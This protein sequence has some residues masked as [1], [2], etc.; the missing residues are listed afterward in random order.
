MY[1]NIFSGFSNV[2][3]ITVAS[4]YAQQSLIMP[5]V[6]TLWAE[7]GLLKTCHTLQAIAN[8]SIWFV[9]RYKYSNIDHVPLVHDCNSN[10]NGGSGL[11]DKSYIFYNILNG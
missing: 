9:S 5:S 7:H 8:R 10:F 3:F 6:R 2:A 4:G 1:A 11:W